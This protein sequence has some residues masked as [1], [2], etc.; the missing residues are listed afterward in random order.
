ML[1]ISLVR[2]PYKLSMY[3]I[4]SSPILHLYYYLGIY[5]NV[6]EVKCDITCENIIAMSY[7]PSMKSAASSPAVLFLARLSPLASYQFDAYPSRLSSVLL[8]IHAC[9]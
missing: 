6:L 7:N 2:C 8:Q 4:N 3:N 5:E 1:L 9:L